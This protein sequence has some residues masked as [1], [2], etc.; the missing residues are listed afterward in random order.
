MSHQT[1]SKMISPPPCEPLGWASPAGGCLDSLSSSSNTLLLAPTACTHETL[2]AHIDNISP[3]SGFSTF[4]LSASRSTRL[5][6]VHAELWGVHRMKQYSRKVI[7][8]YK[9][10][11]YEIGD[12]TGQRPDIGAHIQGID[13]EGAQLSRTEPALHNLSNR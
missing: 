2:S 5:S 9:A 12:H 6:S 8:T 4:N 11:L 7:R 3:R 10:Y 13:D 1:F